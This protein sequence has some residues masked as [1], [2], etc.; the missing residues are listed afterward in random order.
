MHIMT[1]QA[2][3]LSPDGKCF[4]FDER[5][6]GFVPA[7]AVGVVVLKR[8]AD[9]ERDQDLIYGVIRGW[10]VNQDGKTNGITAPNPESQTRLQQ[11][12]YD[13]F[14]I[15]PAQ[16]QLLEA[17]GTGTKLG[18]PIEIE[19]LKTS[20]GKYT[21]KQGYCAVG[22]VKSNIG[23]ALTAAGVAGFI[24][25]MLALKHRQLPPTI[26]F[27]R[28]NEHISLQ[29]SPFY[30]NS[31]LRDWELHGA[32][33]RQ[34]AIS[35]FGFSGT[36]CHIVVAEHAPVA[37]VKAPV[38]VIAPNG[39]L[40]IAL[41]ARTQ[42]Q[43]RQRA[44]DLLS[45]VRSPT[46]RPRTLLE[47]AYTLQVGRQAMDHRLGLM[48][49]SIEQLAQRLRAYLDGGQRGEGIYRG[50]VKQGRESLHLILQDD[51]VRDTLVEKYLGRSDV[52]KLLQLWAKGV[53]IDWNRLY[54]TD[55]PQRIALPL[56]PFAKER[57]WLEP[58][59]GGA[60]HAPA[61]QAHLHPLVHTNTSDF[62]RQ[63]YTTRLTGGEH[64]LVD[65]VVRGK[66]VLPGAASLE[67]ARAAVAAALG[68]PR[69]ESFTLRNVVWSKALV[70]AE[71]PQ[72]VQV[73]L[74]PEGADEVRYEIASAPDD[75]GVRTIYST[76]RV[77]SGVDPAA[78]SGDGSLD[79]GQVDRKSVV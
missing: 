73:V 59:H 56:Y 44:A 75:E 39:M 46:T 43:L 3:M 61:T 28:L 26:N 57:Y 17:H 5:A 32:S 37:P 42:E 12:V 31:T 6:N 20:F 76:G 47:I 33:Q 30:V 38:S 77:T 15:D 14:R 48:A 25:L 40:A 79:L 63:S 19:G 23:H 36:N 2:G 78:V 7:E 58:S 24:K 22:S 64:F 41:S 8:L 65:H 9:A 45:F 52:A 27:A 34:A 67:M 4:T 70:V 49:A 72:V 53:D 11:A 16:I 74:H 10:G 54:G 60:V 69:Q 29:D 51:D 1:S 50:Q 35:S 68:R 62:S 21:R 13:R 18:D 55:K 66:K 71:E